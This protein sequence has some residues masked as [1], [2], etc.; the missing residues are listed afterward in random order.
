MSIR[1]AGVFVGV[2]FFVF[3]DPL[4]LALRATHSFHTALGVKDL[5]TD[6]AG[7]LKHQGRRAASSR[8]KP[9]SVGT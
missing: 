4:V 7:A 8:G 9:A 2:G 3:Q 6:S 1:F 5:A